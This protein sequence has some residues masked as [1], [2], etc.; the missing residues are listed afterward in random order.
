ME[1][2]SEI[3]K[4]YIDKKSR[5]SELTSSENKFLTSVLSDLSKDKDNLDKQAAKSDNIRYQSRCAN[6]DTTTETPFGSYEGSYVNKDIIDALNEIPDP[7]NIFSQLE[8]ITQ[9]SKDIPIDQLTK[10]VVDLITNETE[11]PIIIEEFKD[12]DDDYG[13]LKN[14]NY[15]YHQKVTSKNVFGIHSKQY[16]AN[17]V[18]NIDFKK[19]DGNLILVNKEKTKDISAIKTIFHEIGHIIEDSHLLKD[20]QQ[21]SEVISSLYGAKAALLLSNIDSQKA[22][23]LLFDEVMLY[24]WILNGTVA[25]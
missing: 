16:S 9:E 15:Y 10:K 6:K 22:K 19:P 21:N 3:P 5:K 18:E 24:N 12:W 8:K 23:S 4:Q 7:Y 20:D 17:N 2:N 25:P 1:N 14:G 11:V 13:Q